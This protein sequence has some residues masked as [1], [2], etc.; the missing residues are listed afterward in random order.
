MS[1]KAMKHYQ[2]TKRDVMRVPTIKGIQYIFLLLKIDPVAARPLFVSIS[3]ITFPEN[4][5]LA[6]VSV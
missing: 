3:S 4:S 6:H 1:S 5:V 2:L